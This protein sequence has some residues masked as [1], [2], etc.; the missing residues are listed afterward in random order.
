MADSDLFVPPDAKQRFLE[1]EG[2]AGA[3]A[4]E[5][6]DWKYQRNIWSRYLELL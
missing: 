3:A 6:V 5:A 2:V 4:V 1:D